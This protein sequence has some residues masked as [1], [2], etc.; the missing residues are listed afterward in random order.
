MS[1]KIARVAM[2]SGVGDGSGVGATVS[3]F[4]ADRAWVA[5]D[6][7]AVVTALVGVA[8]ELAE[9]V[10]AGANVEDMTAFATAL[11]MGGMAALPKS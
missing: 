1:D 4:V 3:A 11:F 6:T 2:G 9:R 7:V 8:F 5:V 10:K